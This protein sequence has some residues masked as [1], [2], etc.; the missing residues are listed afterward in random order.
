ML[1]HN[2]Y[3]KFSRKGVSDQT[4]FYGMYSSKDHS[5]ADIRSRRAINKKKGD[6]SR[7]VVERIIG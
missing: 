1:H 3:P 5:L 6:D 2:T 4:V 7:H